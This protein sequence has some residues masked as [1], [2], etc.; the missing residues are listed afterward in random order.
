MTC[1]ANSTAWEPKRDLSAEKFGRLQPLRPCMKHRKGGKKGYKLHWACQCDC[2]T[3]R[4]VDHANL[5]NGNSRSCGCLGR[6]SRPT[7]VITTERANPFKRYDKDYRKGVNHWRHPWLLDDPIRESSIAYA[8]ALPIGKQINLL[9][10]L[11]CFG[12][13]PIYA[14]KMFG[15]GLI[16]FDAW[17]QSLPADILNER[18][19]RR[20]DRTRK[21]EVRRKKREVADPTR[22]VR[23]AIASHVW[24]VLRHR[25][26][27]SSV[28]DMLGYGVQ[29]LVDHIE[30]QWLPGMSWLNYGFKWHIDH[31]KP[32]SWFDWSGPDVN[33]TVRECWSLSNL[34]PL[35]A[36]DNIAKSNRFEST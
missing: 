3:E 33:A 1:D 36:S 34:Q 4:V 24:A 6:D 31:K 17:T 28:M 2:G 19:S 32:V 11:Y 35:W 16:E 12:R 26:A 9:E 7:G 15:M 8:R 21:R 14:A 22:K 5:L 18:D 27:R 29:D 23:T 10:S 13:S 20:S 25:K 30:K